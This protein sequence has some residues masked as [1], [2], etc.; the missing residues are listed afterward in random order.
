[1]FPGTTMLDYIFW[2]VIGALQVL[3]IA[4]AYAWLKQYGRKI[5]WWQM[6]LLYLGFVS[7]CLV[8]A[9]GF[10]LMGEFESPAGYYFMGVFGLPV[11]IVFALL[12]RLFILPKKN[13]VR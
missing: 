4:G 9:G 8:V 3:I 5:T 13:A 2:M 12:V 11:I 1:M 10:T 7:F 6:T